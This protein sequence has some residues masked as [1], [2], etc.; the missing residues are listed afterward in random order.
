MSLQ[1][2]MLIPPL[3]IQMDQLPKMVQAGQK[4]L[5]QNLRTARRA[6]GVSQVGKVHKGNYHGWSKVSEDQD[7]SVQ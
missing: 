5:E 6:L 2:L 3:P 1:L 7:S 4:G